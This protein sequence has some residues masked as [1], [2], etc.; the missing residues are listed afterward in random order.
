MPISTVGYAEPP[1]LSKL[2]QFGTGGNFRVFVS[3]V[4]STKKK[5]HTHIIYTLLLLESTFWRF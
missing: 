1:P 4:I 5:T 3:H 2:Y